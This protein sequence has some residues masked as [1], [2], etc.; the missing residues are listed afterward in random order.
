ME[1]FQD[2]IHQVTSISPS[3]QRRTY[4]LSPI[5]AFVSDNLKMLSILVK[6]RHPNRVIATTS[7]S[8]LK[9]LN[10]GSGMVVLVE[11][12]ANAVSS[13]PRESV[14][15]TP[16]PLYSSSHMQRRIIDA[17]NSCLFNAVGYGVGRGPRGN[18]QAFRQIIVDTIL[19]HPLKYTAAVLGHSTVEDYCRWIL[20]P[21]SWGGEIELSIL[22]HVFNVEIMAVD[23]ITLNQY[24]YNT[25]HASQ[26]I[27]VMYDGV[28][29]DAIGECPEAGA[30][31][32][33]DTTRFDIVDDHL[34]GSPDVVI[35]KVM[36]LVREAHD[37]HQ[38]TDVANFSLQCLVCR[39]GLTGQKDA[40]AHAQTTGHQNFSEYRQA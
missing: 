34:E 30:P 1:V 25:G 36:Q 2:K 4:V 17:D 27:F 23:I 8:T 21:N 40:L 33:F 13:S 38:Y 24:V 29:Y 6:T 32:E 7:T 3:E 20:L 18:G 37:D 22:S 15:P 28:H 31:L 16:V 9:E 35:E 10:L 14:I 19:A 5:L 26:R 12:M 11:K 39:T